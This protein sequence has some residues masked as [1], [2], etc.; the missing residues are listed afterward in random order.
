M[1]RGSI[2]RSRESKFAGLVKGH[3]FQFIRLLNPDRF[4]S[5]VALSGFS[6]EKKKKKR[7]RKSRSFYG[8]W[9]VNPVVPI[10]LGKR[11]RDGIIKLGMKPSFHEYN[12]EHTIPNDCLKD[13]MEWLKKINIK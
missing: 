4:N 9:E 7:V 3:P 12:S 11:T 10:N 2:F 5:V 13:F 6:V 1:Y 8:A